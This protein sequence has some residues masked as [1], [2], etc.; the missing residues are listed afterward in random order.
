M[1]L[2]F[3][4]FAS[5]FVTPFAMAQQPDPLASFKEVVAACEAHINARPAERVRQLSNGEW[6]RNVSAPAAVSFDVKKTDSLVS[7]YTAYIKVESMEHSA[8]RKS[9]EEARTAAVGESTAVHAVYELRY[10]FQDA[11][12]KLTGGSGEVK[13]KAAG[14]ATFKATAGAVQFKP[15]DLSSV[16][17]LSKCAV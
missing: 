10:A 7:P 14:E 8:R 12:W 16:A 15:E 2:G 1:K 3:L 6:V 11:K 17:W 5:V 13:T 4:V 9:E